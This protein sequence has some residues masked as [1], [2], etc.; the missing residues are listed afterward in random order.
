MS[1]EAESP[2]D[3]LLTRLLFLLFLYKVLE[4]SYL[5]DAQITLTKPLTPKK[6]KALNPLGSRSP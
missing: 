6:S 5:G 3:Y 2:V 1:L 4:E